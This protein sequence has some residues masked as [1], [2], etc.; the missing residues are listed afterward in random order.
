MNLTHN[1]SLAMHVESWFPK[2]GTLLSLSFLS[3]KLIVPRQFVF[4]F[5]VSSILTDLLNCSPVFFLGFKV[6]FTRIIKSQT[7][8]LVTVNLAKI[9]M[10]ISF[11]K[12]IWKSV[13]QLLTVY[14]S[15]IIT[16][17]IHQKS[18]AFSCSTTRS[19]FGVVYFGTF[20]YRKSFISYSICLHA[21]R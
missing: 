1:F 9:R 3:R 2:L 13:N 4:Q 10:M 17:F 12:N 8:L 18:E 6:D 16:F 14:Y 15:T 20:N 21:D 11:Y 19:T 7:H 5:F